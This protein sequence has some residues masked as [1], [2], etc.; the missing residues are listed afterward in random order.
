MGGKV[1]L[2]CN[3]KWPK[4]K[5]QKNSN[6]H[7]SLKMIGSNPGYL[8]KFSLLYLQK[9]DSIYESLAKNTSIFTKLQ[10][11]FH[12]VTAFQFENSKFLHPNENQAQMRWPEW[13]SNLLLAQRRNYKN[14]F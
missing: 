5:K 7:N 3:G 2:R 9:W 12:Q 11:K 4:N 6:G 13:H 14:D 10:I 8:L 1:G